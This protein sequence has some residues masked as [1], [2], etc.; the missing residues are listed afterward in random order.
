LRLPN[1]LEGFCRLSGVRIEVLLGKWFIVM[2][3]EEI[4]VGKDEKGLA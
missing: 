3:I 4:E 2:F 1:L